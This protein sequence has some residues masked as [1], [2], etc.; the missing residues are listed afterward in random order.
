LKHVKQEG[1]N[2]SKYTLNGH[3]GMEKIFGI[4]NPIQDVKFTDRTMPI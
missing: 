4:P 1:V 3:E 2:V